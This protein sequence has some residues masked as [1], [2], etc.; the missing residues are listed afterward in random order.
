MG[1]KPQ[2]SQKVWSAIAAPGIGSFSG[3]ACYMK[4]FRDS[5]GQRLNAA[6]SFRSHFGAGG[7]FST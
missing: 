6:G 2:K 1:I 7:E 5:T 3:T 4:T